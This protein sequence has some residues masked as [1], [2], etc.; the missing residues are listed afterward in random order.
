LNIWPPPPRQKPITMIKEY[1]GFC[2]EYRGEI[3]AKHKGELD[4]YF[5]AISEQ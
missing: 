3:E 1:P 4:M 5:V 2:L